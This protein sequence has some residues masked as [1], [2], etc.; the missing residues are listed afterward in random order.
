M[1]NT[2]FIKINDDDW[3]NTG[4]IYKVQEYFRTDPKST[5]VRLT[6]EHNGEQIKKVVPYHWIEWIPDGDW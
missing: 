2:G 6:L 5:A 3:E 4:K 1:N